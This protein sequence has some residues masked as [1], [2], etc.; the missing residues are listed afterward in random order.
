MKYRKNNRS[1]KI[2]MAAFLLINMIQVRED[3]FAEDVLI[4]ITHSVVTPDNP[5][6]ITPSVPVVTPDN[7]T[8]ITS[9]SPTQ[10]TKNPEKDIFQKPEDFV[11][12]EDIVKNSRGQST[13][14]SVNKVQYE[15]EGEKNEFNP[16]FFRIRV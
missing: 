5:T 7:P 8:P 1:G 2:I 10:I 11:K 6:P 13:S 4:E 16:C 3:V 14:E 12:K 15:L 9:D